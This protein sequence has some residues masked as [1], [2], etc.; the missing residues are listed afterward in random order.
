MS[1]IEAEPA[2]LTCEDTSG[3]A[4]VQVL[5]AR[6]VPLGGPRAMP[7]RRTLPQRLPAPEL[8][9]AVLKPRENPVN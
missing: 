7:V 4:G 6:A 2:E 5:E 9:N 1:N 8:P 3:P